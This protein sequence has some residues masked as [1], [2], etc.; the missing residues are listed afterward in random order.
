MPQ[1]LR[2]HAKLFA[3]D[4]SRFPTIT[5]P[6]ISSSNLNEHLLEIRQW[7]YQCKMLF[8]PD[9]T[10][11]TQQTVFLERKMIQVIQVYSNAQLQQQSVQKYLA[12]FL[13][14]KL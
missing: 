7:T 3:D 14:E 5:N 1:R 11:K 8:N 2:C 6:V 13:D 10:K 9:I 4:T 12:R